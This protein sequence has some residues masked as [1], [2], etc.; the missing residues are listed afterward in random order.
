MTRESAL[1]TEPAEGPPGTLARTAGNG[2]NATL[3]GVA[4]EAGVSRATVS[5]VV[6]GSPKVSADVRRSVERAVSRLGYVPNPAAR[7]LVTRRSDSVGLVIT[8]PASRLFDD[9]F[10]PRLLRGISAEL[11]ARNLQLV[12]LMPEDGDAERRLERYLGAGHVDGVVLVS[13]HG[14]DPL[15]AH[16]QARGVPMVVG[17]RPPAGVTASYVDVDNHEAAMSAVRHLA[18]LGRRRIATITG[19]VDMGAGI[20]R[21]DGYLDGLAELGIE[22]DDRLVAQADFTYVGGAAAMRRLLASA[23]DL[24]AVFA[25]SDLMAAGALNVLRTA[26]RTVPGDVAVVGFDDSPL[27][28]ATEPPLTSVRQPIEEMGRELVRLLAESL[29]RGHRATRRVLLSTELVPRGSSG[30]GSP[31]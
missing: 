22:R 13:L 19:P 5:R 16:L 15:P 25:A 2:R 21:L 30:G 8:E 3:D 14:D 26:G 12:L 11:S 10:F 18:G 27:A 4:K 31:R 28:A 7:S 9:P 24:D 29:E 23:P 17:G 6:N 1:T 20:D